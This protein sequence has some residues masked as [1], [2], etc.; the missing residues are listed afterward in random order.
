MRRANSV[1]LT[2]L[3][4]ALAAACAGGVAHDARDADVVEAVRAAYLLER[5]VLDAQPRLHSRA[6][7]AEIY[8]EGFSDDLAEHLADLSWSEP[9]RTVRAGGFALEPPTPITLV[10]VDRDEATVAFPTPIVQQLLWEEK[11]YTTAT[12]ER[13]QGRWIITRSITS[14]TKPPSLGPP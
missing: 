7:V 14:E 1:R 3:L 5:R 8:R 13:R 10:E 6:A 4:P 9:G 11:R 12:L 2:L